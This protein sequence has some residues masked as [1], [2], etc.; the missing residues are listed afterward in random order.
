MKKIIVNI[1]DISDE[2]LLDITMGHEYEWIDA[3]TLEYIK[4]DYEEEE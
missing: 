4:Y 3:E 1:N 2:M